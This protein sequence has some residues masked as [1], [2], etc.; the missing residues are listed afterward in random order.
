MTTD[1]IQDIRRDYML[2]SLDVSDL[3]PDAIEMFNKWFSE[4][5]K[6]Q[7]ADVTAMSLATVD[8][9]LQPTSRIVLLKGVE[10]G[11]FIF[12]TN[13]ESAKGKEIA[14]NNR[15]GLCFYWPELERQIRIEGK[16][17]KLDKEANESYFNSRPYESRLGAWASHQSSPVQSR[18][19]L[20]AQYSDM[21]EE[22]P[23]E[24]N[25][26]LPPYWGGYAVKAH[27]IEF[28]QG[29]AS[30]LHDRFQYEWVEGSWKITRLSP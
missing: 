20:E 9:N 11:K 21:K 3:L 1:N 17:V 24:N 22:Y 5:M 15:V 25:V 13:Y 26:P 12:Y 28:W 10:K 4:A 30:R 2:E 27:R 23:D 18:E 29:R 6:S 7:V 16:A 8:V 14:Q 19:Q